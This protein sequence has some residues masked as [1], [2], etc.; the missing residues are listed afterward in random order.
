MSAWS[1]RWSAKLLVLYEGLINS[2]VEFSSLTPSLK[3]KKKITSINRY[4]QAGYTF[5]GNAW[6]KRPIST[7]D[8]LMCVFYSILCFG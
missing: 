5:D 7:S 8:K 1:N 4:L 3:L 2:F 6:E